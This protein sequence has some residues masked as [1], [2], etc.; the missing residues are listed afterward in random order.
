MHVIV[1][2]EYKK[3]YIRVKSNIFF[4]H[5]IQ[6]AERGAQLFKAS[7]ACSYS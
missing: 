6:E 4:L 5:H 3:H 2:D 7:Y 1:K